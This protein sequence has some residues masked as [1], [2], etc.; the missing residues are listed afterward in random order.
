IH[1]AIRSP[2]SAMTLAQSHA[3]F[4]CTREELEVLIKPMIADG[5]EAVGSM[6]DDTPPAVLSSRSRLLTDFFRQRFAQVTHPPVDPYR[7]SAVMSLTSLVGGQ[8]LF[9][10]ELAP[11]PPRIALRSPILSER[12]LAQLRT[13]ARLKPAFIALLGASG[14]SGAAALARRLVAIVAE[15]CAAVDNGC[16]LI[17]LS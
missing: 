3:L 17:V 14:E 6:G 12:Q 16:A 7:E 5:H 8:G 13:A 2:Q 9:F 4:G 1:P 11:R 15:A 10:D